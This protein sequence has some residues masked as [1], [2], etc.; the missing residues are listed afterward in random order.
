M[1]AWFFF[2]GLTSFARLYVSQV[3]STASLVMQHRTLVYPEK[4]LPQSGR[5][6][7]SAHM[8]NS[9]ETCESEHLDFVFLLFSY[10]G[11]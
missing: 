3:S 4:S 6:C 7:A 1:L 10:G 8:R 5:D 11:M 9:S 2:Y